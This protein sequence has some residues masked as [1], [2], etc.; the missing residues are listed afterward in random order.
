MLGA[1]PYVGPPNIPRIHPRPARFGEMDRNRFYAASLGR[2]L[3][4]ICQHPFSSHQD[5]LIGLVMQKQCLGGIPC[6]L[7]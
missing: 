5:Y 3:Y 4:P 2:L 6:R 7:R 1:S